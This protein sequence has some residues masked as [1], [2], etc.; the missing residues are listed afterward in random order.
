MPQ[1]Y[2][3][4]HI[5]DL[6]LRC[7]IGIKPEEREKKQRV[8]INV[9]LHCSLQDACTTD[10]IDHT[11]DYKRVKQEIVDLV[12]GSSFF[13]IETLAWHIAGLCLEREG[14][15]EADVTVDKPGALRYA[16]S[17]AVEICR[18]K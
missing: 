2:D 14:V 15:F 11:I 16:R 4:M 12:D 1:A 5:R 13:L 10:D 18:R 3:K 7:I 6:S 8:R 9:T 17:V